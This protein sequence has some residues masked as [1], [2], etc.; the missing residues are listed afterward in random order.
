[1]YELIGFFVFMLIMF[2]SLVA[3]PFV[4]PARRSAIAFITDEDL[5]WIR[6]SLR[7]IEGDIEMNL[8]KFITVY[9][10]IGLFMFMIAA[11]ISMMWPILIPAAAATFYA[12]YRK[13]SQK[14]K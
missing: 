5:S 13:R 4:G 7:F 3:V 2:L 1:M 14:S 9:L 11:I 8:I 6:D 12:S 10:G